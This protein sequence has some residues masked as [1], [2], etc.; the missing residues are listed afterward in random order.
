MESN[1]NKNDEDSDSSFSSL[2]EDS[3]F[4]ELEDFYFI[5][6]NNEQKIII[7]NE[8]FV[9]QKNTIQKEFF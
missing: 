5:P 4:Q 7:V 9:W 3:D 6:Q 8:N 1:Q 2:S